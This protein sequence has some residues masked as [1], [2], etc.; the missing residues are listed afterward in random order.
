[1]DCGKVA[2]LLNSDLM[3]IAAQ[4]KCHREI[5]FVYYLPVVGE[6]RTLIQGVA[7]LVIEEDD[8]LTVVDYKASNAPPEILSERY[9]KQLEIYSSAMEKIFSKP[10]KGRILF[11]ILRNY[12]VDV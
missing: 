7:D 6:D 4:G 9:A 11:N 1:M 2:E 3:R 10:V 12:T 8:S 5:P